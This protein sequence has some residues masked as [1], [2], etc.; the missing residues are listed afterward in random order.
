MVPTPGEKPRSLSFQWPLPGPFLQPVCSD[1]PRGPE[2]PPQG[3][4]ARAGPPPGHAACAPEASLHLG[5]L[6][7]G[8]T[9][10]GGRWVQRPRRGCPPT[11]MCRGPSERGQG[12]VYSLPLRAPPW[13]G[14]N[15]G[16]AGWHRNVTRGGG[17][18]TH[19]HSRTCIHRFLGKPHTVTPIL[20]KE[21]DVTLL[22]WPKP[23]GRVDSWPGRWPL[24]TNQ[25]PRGSFRDRVPEAA[26]PGVAAGAPVAPA[27]RPA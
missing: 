11:G 15:W 23:K 6:P 2:S 7:L 1:R 3:S 22:S 10:R 19:A 9:A 27:R 14:F 18:K 20:T 4:R 17:V 12:S 13:R 5:G 8:K 21:T 26:V 24:S 25:G 16:R